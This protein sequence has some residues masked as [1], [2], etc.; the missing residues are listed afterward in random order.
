M[1]KKE[2]NQETKLQWSSNTGREIQEKD[3]KTKHHSRRVKKKKDLNSIMD[4]SRPLKLLE[5]RSRQI[6]HIKQCGTNLQLTILRWRLKLHVQQSNKSTTL[7][8][9][10]QQIPNKQKIILHI[11]KAMGQWRR[12]WFTNSPHLLHIKH[13]SRTT[14]CFFRRLSIVRILPKATVQEK[15][16][17][18]GGTFDC[19]TIFQGKDMP[20]EGEVEW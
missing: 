6:H 7:W 11:L 2:K 3:G 16:A 14:R 19:H 15:K 12:R 5:F 4:H 8:G 1:Y 18:R 17:T 10:T 13:H 20:V 9:I